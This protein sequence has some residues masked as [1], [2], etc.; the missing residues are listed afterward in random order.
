MTTELT[1]LLLT[2]LLTGVLW[3]PAVIG[4]VKS[5]GV[6]TPDNYVTLPDSPLLDW[7]KRADRAHQNA[8]ENFGIFAAVVLV[9]HVTDANTALTATCA[10]IYF[11][12]RVAH[13]IV[14]ITGFKH[15]MARTFIFTIAWAAWLVM[16]LSL[17]L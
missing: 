9:A 17:L 7:A 4:Q 1:Y 14:F 12:A 8:L 11:F 13:A 10:A 6:L 2:A 3:I 15:F 5:R 16:A